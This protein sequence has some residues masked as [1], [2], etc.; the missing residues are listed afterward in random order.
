MRTAI[1]L[2]TSRINGNTA[3]LCSSLAE[4]IGAKI[5]SLSEYEINPF[6]Y[7]FRN[8]NDDFNRLICELLEYEII[9]F[10]TPVY[11]YSPSSQLKVF[12]D[13]ISDL[14][15]TNK[16]LGRQLRQKKA[17]LLATGSDTIPRSCFEDIFKFTFDHLGMHHLG[18]LYCS[19]Q[20]E[21]VLQD[22]LQALDTYRSN[23]LRF[24]SGVINA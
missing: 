15:T 12:M 22:H 24:F 8:Q 6:D 1:V 3:K 20:N 14:L 11:W 9:I 21:F 16:P 5:F 19:C 13:R 10:A 23:N 18:M 7:E 2:G 4:C 17:G